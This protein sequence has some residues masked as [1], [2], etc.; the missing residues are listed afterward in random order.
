[1][2]ENK[3]RSVS[4]SHQGSQRSMGFL[5]LCI[6]CVGFPRGDIRSIVLQYCATLTALPF[7][8][9]QPEPLHVEVAAELA[10]AVPFE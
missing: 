8:G 7:V 4:M 5:F 6:L 3:I 2:L 10:L 9:T 1:V